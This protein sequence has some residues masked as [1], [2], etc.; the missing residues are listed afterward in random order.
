M[1][2]DATSETGQRKKRI[3]R[4]RDNK[5]PM[6]STEVRICLTGNNGRRLPVGKII[7]RSVEHSARYDREKPKQIHIFLRAPLPTTERLLHG[8]IIRDEK[9][10]LSRTPCSAKLEV[11]PR[12]R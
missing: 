4:G 11:N 8:G 6:Q 1:S 7:Y 12:S 10:R 3:Q 5:P 2:N 9:S